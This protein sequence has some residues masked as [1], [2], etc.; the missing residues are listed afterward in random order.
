MLVAAKLVDEHKGLPPS[1][2]VIPEDSDSTLDLSREES[3]G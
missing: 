3:L 1:Y 2:S